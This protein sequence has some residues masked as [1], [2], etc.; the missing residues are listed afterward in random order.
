MWCCSFSYSSNSRSVSTRTFARTI[1]P[2]PTKQSRRP[3]LVTSASVATTTPTS[4]RTPTT[5]ANHSKH[6]PQLNRKSPGLY[7][8]IKTFLTKEV[9]QD[10]PRPQYSNE[11]TLYD[12]E[13]SLLTILK[14]CLFLKTRL[15]LFT[16]LLY[17]RS[18][19]LQN[20]KK[21]IKQNKKKQI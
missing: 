9:R 8:V 18:L 15:F 1:C 4:H 3:V 6:P 10:Q 7:R 20:G 5:T 17:L 12:S 13:I 16:F 19:H 2:V 14:F 21:K 11:I